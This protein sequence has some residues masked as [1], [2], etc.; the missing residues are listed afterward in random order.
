MGVIKEFKKTL[1]RKDLTKKQKLGIVLTSSGC[2]LHLASDIYLIAYSIFNGPESIF[3]CMPDYVKFN[4]AL[5]I[6]IFTGLRLL[7]GKTK[8]YEK[9]TE[10]IEKLKEYK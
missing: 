5:A 8:F 7:Y 6:P 3:D 10:S 2:E 9:L 4:G 1:K